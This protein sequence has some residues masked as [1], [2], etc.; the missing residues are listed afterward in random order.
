MRKAFEVFF[1]SFSRSRGKRNTRGDA[2]RCVL[3][4][5]VCCQWKRIGRGGGLVLFKE[6]T[7]RKGA[8]KRF[9]VDVCFFP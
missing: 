2:Q 4:D 8:V 9:G 1:V 5:E 3:M 7:A 6:L